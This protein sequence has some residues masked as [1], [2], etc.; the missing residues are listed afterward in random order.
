MCLSPGGGAAGSRRRRGGTER[1]LAEV[2]LVPGQN[3]A[4]FE[5]VQRDETGSVLG[6]S[7]KAHG[8]SCFVF[9]LGLW[10]IKDAF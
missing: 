3:K 1:L 10:P 4:M 8:R 5:A 7:E 6:V 9:L 2:L